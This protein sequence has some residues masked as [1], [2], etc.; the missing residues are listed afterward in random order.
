M[1]KKRIKQSHK[2]VNKKVSSY[3]KHSSLCALAPIISEKEIFEPIHQ[4]VQIPQKT[5]IYR[6]TDKLVFVTLGIV[7]GSET[8]YDLN[9]NLRVDQ[10]LLQA[11][12]YEQ[13]AD[14][15]VIQETLN[16]ATEENVEQL[17]LALKTIW[18]QNNLT[19]SLLKDAKIEG[20]LV[21]ID[22]DLSGQPTSKN[23]EQSTKGYFAGKKNVYGRQLARVLVSD[24]QEIV[25]ESLYPGNTLSCSVFKAMVK[26]MERLLPLENKAQ[27]SLIRIRLDAGFGTDA[28]INFALWRGYHLLAKIYSSKRAKLLAKSVQEWVD[29]PSDT[30]GSPRQAGWVKKPHRYGRKTKQVAVRTPKRKGGYTYTVLVTTDFSA[31]IQTI[32]TD[33]DKRS[34]VPES[35]FCQ[36]NQGLSNRKR[37]KRSFIAQKM[38]T[39][40]TQLAHNLIRWF[41]N[42]M[43]LAVEQHAD[44]NVAS[45]SF[46]DEKDAALVVKTLKERGMKRFVRQIL[47]I[48]GKVVI[49]GK[50]VIRIILNPLYPLINRIKTAF[51]ALL[52][53]YGITVS[54]DKS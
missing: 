49:K 44:A 14:Q 45:D 17:E 3:S 52:S 42:W 34:G 31:D 50:R 30:L 2:N 41:Q 8:V 28:N 25:A 1:A 7:A 32:V 26:K 12:G 53:N 19:I 6:P 40:L 5:V 35:N 24:T 10:P 51:S 9:Q 48:S 39:L 47:S 43:I 33:Y 54:L 16:A 20:K 36:D 11:F 23:A 13:C 29:V 46:S 38:L 4:S 22:I 27:R 21:T 37:R 18:D 15:S